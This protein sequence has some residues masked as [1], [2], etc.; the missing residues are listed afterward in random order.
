MV[1]ERDEWKGASVGERI[2]GG[3]PELLA[4]AGTFDALCA[5]VA[6]GADAVY[7]GVGSFNARAGNA[8]LTMGEL[9]CGCAIAHA[10]GARVYVTLNVYVCDAEL[11]EVVGVAGSALDA[12]A[13]A[14][15]VADAGLVET[16]R[17]RIP[18]VEV[19]LSTQAGVQSVDAVRMMARELG[20]ERVTCAREL[21]VD[22]LAALAATGVHIEAFC[23]GAICIC[24]S[25]ACSYS[26]LRRGRSA[27]RGDC[28]QPCRVGYALTDGSG[29]VLAGGDVAR[30]ADAGDRLLCPR[31]YCSI[32]HI[33]ELVAVGV[34][35]LKIEGRMKNPDYVYNVVSVYRAALDAVAA[36]EPYDA[37]AFE[38]QL[39]R[40]FNRGFT[41]AYLRGTSGSELMSTE[42]AINQGL[43]A[44]RVVERGYEEVTVAFERAA[45][46]GD[47]LEIRST[48]APD[49]PSDVPKRWPM[50]PCPDDFPAGA[51]AKI[52]CKRKVE[53]GSP[54]HVVRSADVL[55][56][57]QRAVGRIRQEA[58]GLGGGGAAR[59]EHVRQPSSRATERRGASDRPAPKVD[60]QAG[61]QRCPFGPFVLAWELSD[62]TAERRGRALRECTVVL[63]E[64]HRDSDAERVRGL[65][66]AARAVVC[67][68][69]GQIDIARDAGVPWGAAAPISV[70]NA[71]TVRW[72]ARLGAQF[73]WA[74]AELA[75]ERVDEL[76]GLA[77]GIL[78][79]FPPE[80]LASTRMVME[81]C[82]LTAEG[83]CG[84]ECASCPRRL[85]SVRGERLLVERAGSPDDPAS[86]CRVYVDALG[87]TRLLQTVDS[88]ENRAPMNPDSRVN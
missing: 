18:G 32:R 21:S 53:V 61:A 36:G 49:A 40:S 70:W 15:I 41:D 79:V 72:L 71:A 55:E 23:H 82:V 34:H 65:C 76:E 63:D 74:P 88:I 50:V 48:P 44:G 27:N 68:N 54:V 86:S 8:G 29:T 30:V 60:G 22:E 2:E 37:D 26:A 25:G 17:T 20:V 59:V 85:A 35:A 66:R 45:A 67:R 1:F 78:P 56:Q 14:L 38:A 31:D 43:Y 77:A 7:A 51:L 13:D 81:H 10:H 87:R 80:P 11:D 57:A 64:A 28:T 4:P 46:A 58:S 39:A 9:E 52:H 83:P 33:P 75:P 42:R 16:L 12:G 19:H 6:A 3:L 73:V 84:G 5:A 47:T 24:Y 69:P 62:M